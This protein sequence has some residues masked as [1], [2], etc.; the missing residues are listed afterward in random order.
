MPGLQKTA[1]ISRDHYG[2]V[3]IKAESLADAYRALG[4][5]H[6]QDRL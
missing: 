1:Q 5:A 4:Y 6:A 2:I 3:F